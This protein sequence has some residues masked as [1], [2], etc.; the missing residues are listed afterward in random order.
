MTVSNGRE[1]LS[2][3]G[4]TTVPDEVL[5]AMHRP[6]I[7]IYGGTLMGIT[8]SCLDDLKMVFKTKG[9]TYIYAANGHGAWE[10]TLTNL[11]S[12][13]DKVLVLES[14]RF[15]IGWGEA[16]T[17]LGIE[18]E[19]LPGKPGRAVDVEAVKTRLLQDSAG[20][21][22][23]VLVVQIDT[24]SSVYNDIAAI[25]RAMDE[26]GHDALFLVDTIASLGIVDYQMDEWGVDVSVGGSQK[27]LMTPP[28]LS[29]NAVSA[30][31]KAVHQTAGLRTSYWDW[32]PRDGEVHYMKFAGTPP[33]HLLYGLHKALD[34]LKDEGLE[35]VFLRHS[36]LAEA[37]RR[38]VQVWAQANVVSFIIDQPEERADSVTSVF[39]NGDYNTAELLDYCHKKCGVVLGVGIGEG[40]ENKF[41]IAHM[42]HI[43]APMI[44]GTLSV[45]EIGL[46]ALNIPHGKGGVQAAIDWLSEKVVAS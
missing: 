42:G 20:E 34:M 44:L 12:K 45:V 23:A 19:I 21:I 9:D 11:F 39:L 16:A 22:K 28:G 37:V 3:P 17:K 30:K 40:S 14:G 7:E 29:F 18:V 24:A 27:G 8:M 5:Q 4:P 31:A 13:G 35:N 41:R 25:R 26:A 33:V 36:L 32:T 2:I 15:A 6:A 38:A 46:A 10:A 1:F 43:N